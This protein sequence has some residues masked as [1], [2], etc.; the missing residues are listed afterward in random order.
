VARVARH[1]TGID[2]TPAMIEQASARQQTLGLSNLS[3]VPG[4]AQP[5]PFP[6]ASFSRVVTRYSFHHFTD[7]TGAFAEMVRVCKPGGRVTVC[8]VF[9][10]SAEQEELYDR[11]E[12][13]REPRLRPAVPE[14]AVLRIGPDLV[15]GRLD[16]LDDPPLGEGVL[17]LLPCHPP[18]P[19]LARLGVGT[20]PVRRH[21]CQ[22]PTLLPDPTSE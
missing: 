12:R 4:D 21:G 22:G 9:T 6:E 1:V 13:H 19:P 2:L 17:D 3:W 18:R 7:T 11:L 15:P 8:D 14:A 10:T 20:H 5:L 16:G